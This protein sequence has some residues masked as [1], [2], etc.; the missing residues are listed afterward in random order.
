M[1]IRDRPLDCSSDALA[2]EAIKDVGPAGHFFATDHTQ[3]R[4]RDAFYAPVLSD[5]RN[6]ESWEEAGRPDAMQKANRVWK[7]RLSNYEEPA[8]DAAIKEELQT[9]VAKRKAEG[10]MATDF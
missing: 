1:C 4:Y 2:F 3:S 10:G 9:F 5:W 8:M 6:Y 7:E